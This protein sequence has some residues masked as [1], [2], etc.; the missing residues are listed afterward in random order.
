MVTGQTLANTDVQNVDVGG[1]VAD[2]VSTRR[3]FGMH[4]AEPVTLLSCFRAKGDLPGR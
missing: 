1:E 3:D 2:P 4:K